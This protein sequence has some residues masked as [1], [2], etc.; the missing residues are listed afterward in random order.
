[1]TTTKMIDIYSKSNRRLNKYPLK[2]LYL[3]NFYKNDRY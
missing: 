1:M 3:V 2:Q